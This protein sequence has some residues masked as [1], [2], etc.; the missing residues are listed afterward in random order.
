M[1][2]IDSLCRN[3]YIYISQLTVTKLRDRH[4]QLADEMI[5]KLNEELKQ[6]KNVNKHGLAE[7]ASLRVQLA[8]RLSPPNRIRIFLG[9]SASMSTISCRQ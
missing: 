4:L 7:N 1:R 8:V 5:R 6:Q 2:R 3:I 9:L